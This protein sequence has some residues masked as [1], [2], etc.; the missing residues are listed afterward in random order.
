MK[1]RQLLL[2]LALLPLCMLGQRTHISPSDA[3]FVYEGRISFAN[4]D[5]PRWHYPGVQ[6]RCTFTGT[7]VR[8]LTKPGSGFF[9]CQID[10]AAPFKVE[11]TTDNEGEITLATG[12]PTALH[13][14]CITYA[15]EG[16]LKHPKF[17]GFLLDDESMWNDYRWNISNYPACA[18]KLKYGDIAALEDNASA[19]PNNAEAAASEEP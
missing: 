5:A 8:L 2:L 11:S 4:A 14:L 12:L 6:I 1:L 10:D 18:G 13:S 15:I 16:L 17:Y 9:I 3:G 19:P 7:S